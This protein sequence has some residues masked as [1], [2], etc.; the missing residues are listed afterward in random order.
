MTGE[1]EFIELADC[2][3]GLGLDQNTL[4]NGPGSLDSM[5]TENFVMVC[6]EKAGITSSHPVVFVRVSFSDM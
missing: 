6:Y 3:L 5:F 4:K 2:G 1:E